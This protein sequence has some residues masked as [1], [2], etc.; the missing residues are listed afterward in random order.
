MTVEF[1]DLTLRE[2]SQVPGLEITDDVGERVLDEVARMGVDRVEVSFPRAAPREELYRHAD[3]L[4]LQTAALARAV[5]ADVDA[6]LDVDP[7]EIE[8]IVN[9]SDVQL[10]HAL[11]KSREESLRL[12]RENVERAVDG[13]VAA[14][15]TLMDAIRADNDHLRDG[16]RVVRDAGGR[17]VTLADTTGAGDPD[18]VRETVA[19][20]VD[21]VGDDLA[22]TI[23]PHDD[24]GVAT[25]NAIAGVD[26]GAD[27]IDATV[28]GVGERAGNAP[29]E[30]VA[31][32]AGERGDDVA[33]DLPE[34]VPACRAVLDA[35]GV[36]YEGKPVLGREG[37]RHESGLHTAAM[38]REPSTYE[39][40]DPGKYGAERELL[41]GR[42]T[43]RGGVRAL[44]EAA[45]LEAT[46]ER[47]AAGR[48]A[49]R[50]AA[51]R[52]GEPLDREEAGRVVADAVGS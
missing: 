9:S 26:A 15:A 48:E 47:V 36:D 39:P 37:Y 27:S 18:A 22:V 50:N 3:S 46:D 32:L 19:A 14:G 38:L 51:E 42:G 41:F 7:D 45:G 16:A 35:L 17:H 49:L 44:L 24:M 10:E 33:L 30:E 40:F 52:R 6:A 28:G 4:G 25:A 21:E 8:V 5:P 34:L 31:V 43:G 1:K 11:G 12:L 13:G 2:G 20:V 29:L 23:H